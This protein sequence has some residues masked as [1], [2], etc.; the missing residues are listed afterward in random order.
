MAEVDL[1]EPIAEQRMIDARAIFPRA[2]RLEIGIA[3][4]NPVDRQ[5][6]DADE[7]IEVEL[8][9]RPTDRNLGVPATA[10]FPVE[11]QTRLQELERP[12]R[13]G[14]A[15]D[16]QVGKFVIDSAIEAEC[17]REG[18]AKVRINFAPLF[19]DGRIG[20]RKID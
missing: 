3:P 5:V 9:D 15:A 18:P 2:L 12:V 6:S 16:V 11:R 19:L 20:D 8:R 13:D 7:I 14:I 17:R 1:E 10:R 4:G